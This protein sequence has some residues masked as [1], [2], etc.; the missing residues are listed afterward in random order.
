MGHL[1]YCNGI[2]GLRIYIAIPMQYK[3]HPVLEDLIIPVVITATGRF[4]SSIFARVVLPHWTG[5]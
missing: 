1:G 4:L 2:I 3:E 5:K